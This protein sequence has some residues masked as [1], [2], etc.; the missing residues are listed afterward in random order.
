MGEGRKAAPDVAE[1]AL[2]WL[3]SNDSRAAIVGSR[4]MA[5]SAKIVGKLTLCKGLTN[6]EFGLKL[7]PAS[8][9]K[10]LL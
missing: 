6:Y 7:T 1:A 4:A 2:K 3:S 10:G 5:A 9:Q 8:Y